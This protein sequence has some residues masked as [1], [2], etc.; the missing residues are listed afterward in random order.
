MANKICTK[1]GL[2]FFANSKTEHICKL[3]RKNGIR[4]SPLPKECEINSDCREII[5]RRDSYRCVYC[6]KSSIEDGVKLHLDHVYPIVKG[7]KDEIL[8]FVTSC[9]R[10]N[11]KKSGIILPKEIILRI[12][13]RNYELNK[14]IK[15]ESY[16]G[17]V[18]LF[19]SRQKRFQ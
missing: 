17:L 3:C 1:C 4:K 8:N 15:D 16:E 18:L 19:K 12:W 6:G 10:C 5:F 14:N 9:A 7:G 2:I 13:E 11:I